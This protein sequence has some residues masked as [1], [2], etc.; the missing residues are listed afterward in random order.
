MAAS[1]PEIDRLLMERA[2]REARRADRAGEVPIGA[3][4]AR[5]PDAVAVG[6]NRTI[7]GCD[8]TAHAEVVALRRAARRLGNHR[9][10]GL[11]LYVTLEPCVMCIGAMVQARIDRL[12]FGAI[13]PKIGATAFLQGDR[14]RQGLNH[15]FAVQGGVLADPSAELLRTFFAGRRRRS[16]S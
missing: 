11:T 15:R 6:H 12:V 7:S 3:V 2:L 8:P 16:Q 9:L 5:G 4:L 13:D 14:I 1:V 10:S